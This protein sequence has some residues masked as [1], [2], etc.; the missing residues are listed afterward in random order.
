MRLPA[1]HRRDNVKREPYT[2]CR[3]FS[4]RIH[5]RTMHR[6]DTHTVSSRGIADASG[7]SPTPPHASYI[8]MYR[9]Y[10]TRYPYTRCITLGWRRLVTTP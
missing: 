8:Y 6:R 4:S 10:H 7:N 2:P 5:A 3:A 1:R 9:V